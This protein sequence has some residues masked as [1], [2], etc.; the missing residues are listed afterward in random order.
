MVDVIER[1]RAGVGALLRFHDMGDDTHAPVI[2]DPDAAATAAT[3]GATTDAAVTTNTTGTLS[4]KLRGLVAILADVW[5]SASHLLM[6]EA[7]ANAGVTIG[8]TQDAGP[9][10]TLSRLYT[11]SADFSTARD[12]TAA[13]TAGQ[14]VVALDIVVSMATACL[15]TV[16]METSHNV[17]AAAYLPA[18]GTMVFTLRGLLKAD[19]ADKKLQVK[20]SAAS[21]GVVTA[22]YYSEA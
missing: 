10:Q 7:Q 2:Y 17:L 4:G 5:V 15:A 3:I 21:A 19:A 13:P 6:V 11:P 1:F 14:K 9:S 12:V 16:E 22:I 8:A 20:S 18:N